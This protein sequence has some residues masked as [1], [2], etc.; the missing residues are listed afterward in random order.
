MQGHAAHQMGRALGSCVRN[1]NQ[2]TVSLHMYLHVS[3]CI[4]LSLYCIGLP[5]CGQREK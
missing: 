1:W 4:A 2:G 5:S 3:S